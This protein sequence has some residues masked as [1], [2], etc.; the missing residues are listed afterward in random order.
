MLGWVPM[1]MN[2]IFLQGFDVPALL[3]SL[4]KELGAHAEAIIQSFGIP[5]HLLAALI[6]GDCESGHG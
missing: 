3:W 4:V 1:Y 5:D 6:T 2:L